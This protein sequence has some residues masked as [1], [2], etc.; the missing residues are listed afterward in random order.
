MRAVRRREG[1]IGSLAT[2]HQGVNDSTLGQHVP[3]PDERAFGRDCAPRRRQPKYGCVCFSNAVG[4]QRGTQGA[5]GLVRPS[6]HIREVGHVRAIAQ[7]PQHPLTVRPIH[8]AKQAA[9]RRQ[10]VSTASSALKNSNSSATPTPADQTPRTVA[11]PPSRIRTFVSAREP[12]RS[13]RMA[14]FPPPLP[15]VQPRR[16]PHMSSS[17]ACKSPARKRTPRARQRSR[18]E[19]RDLTSMT[20]RGGAP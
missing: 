3:Q 1:R 7:L 17:F 14:P 12:S 15:V 13:F 16:P 6:R 5:S 4:H 9:R 8:N 18:F 10:R 20:A 11:L 2:R 19:S